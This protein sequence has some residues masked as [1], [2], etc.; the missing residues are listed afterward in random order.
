MGKSLISPL[1][2]FLIIWQ[3]STG[4]FNGEKREESGSEAAVVLVPKRDKL[5]N[6]R[7][8]KL[9]KTQFNH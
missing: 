5:N 9:L 1:R 7:L 4:G 3:I 6:K 2:S 8:S